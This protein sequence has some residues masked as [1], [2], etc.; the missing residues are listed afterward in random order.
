MRTNEN[1]R[2]SNVS[3]GPDTAGSMMAVRR[4]AGIVSLM[5]MSRGR[6]IGQVRRIGLLRCGFSLAV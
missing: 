2:L 6:D 4:S 1:K 3:H 5:V